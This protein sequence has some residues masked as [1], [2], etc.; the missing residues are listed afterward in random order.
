[1]LPA[2]PAAGAAA[3]VYGAGEA[4]VDVGPDATLE[5]VLLGA[6]LV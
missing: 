3:P 6:D 5:M 1:M 2:A 4:V